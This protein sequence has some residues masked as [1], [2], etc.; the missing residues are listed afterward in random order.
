MTDPIETQI[1][2]YAHDVVAES[3]PVDLTKVMRE[4]MAVRPLA[5]EA[6]LEPDGQSTRYNVRRHRGGL[7]AA[8]AAAFVLIVFGGVAWLAPLGGGAPPAGEPTVTTTLSGV[9]SLGGIV[10][11]GSWSVAAALPRSDASLA[12]MADVATQMSTWPGVIEVA[13]AQDDTAWEQ[14]TGLAGDCADTPLCGVGIVALVTK[15]WMDE[16]ASRLKADFGLDAITP[17]DAPQEFWD[18]YFEHVSSSQVALVFDPGALGAQQPLNGPI[19]EASGEVCDT[20][21][22]VVET[23]VDGFGVVA[24]VQFDSDGTGVFEVAGT[25]G[26]EFSINDLLVDGF[27][28]GGA[29]AVL[30]AFTELE[31]PIGPRRIYAVAGLPID[32]AVVT[33][34]LVD[35]TTVWQQPVVGM[36]L[37][38]DNVG[39]MPERFVDYYDQGGA[40]D[41]DELE[42]LGPARPLVVLDQDGTEIM[43]IE[44][45]GNG[46]SVVTDLRIDLDVIRTARVVPL[47]T[48]RTAALLTG[49]IVYSKGES[50]QDASDTEI[51]TMD[52]DGTNITRLTDSQGLDTSPVWSPDRTRIAFVSDR[53]GNDEIYAMDV[54]GANVTR[55]TDSV[56]FDRNPAWSPDGSRI[57]YDSERD[58]LNDVYV[59]D[60]DGS[61]VTNL[62]NYPE[63]S[64]IDPS[65]SPDGTRI[66]FVRTSELYVMDADGSN[67]TRLPVFDDEP[68]RS[69]VRL[70]DTAF[71]PVWS[72]D[73]TRIAFG[74]WVSNNTAA[75]YVVNADGSNVTP[76]AFDPIVGAWAPAWSPD[77]ARIVYQ[78]ASI[79]PGQ[80]PVNIYVMDADGS[81]V[82]Q[83]SNGPGYTGSPTWAK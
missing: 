73:G 16:T 65:W 44:D 17:L 59:M 82:I 49:K 76:L 69:I 71:S 35:G 22:L 81:N 45:V 62:T 28:N 29:I 39:S 24:G 15:T 5:M 43:R 75:I 53:D 58:G 78:A 2:D 3:L 68:A 61:N 38:V 6:S 31:S 42:E 13:Q 50:F 21:E 70:A 51:Y 4:D 33:M 77:S 55:L 83:L 12:M 23:E 37:F 30:D 10:G 56:G 48:S 18:G 80:Q 20:C 8:V 79:D 41:L 54:D 67:V 32:A 63:N 11:P 52:A 47:P 25:S 7:V 74:T 64:S 66:V 14:L 19:L 40:V 72:P 34:E 57:A 9:S 1:R 36:A 60:A 46:D 27:G 26:T